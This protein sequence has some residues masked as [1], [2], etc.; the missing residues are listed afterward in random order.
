MNNGFWADRAKFIGIM[1]MLLAHDS[2]A[3]TISFL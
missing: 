2:L 3:I 1:L